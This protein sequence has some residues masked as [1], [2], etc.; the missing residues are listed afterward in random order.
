MGRGGFKKNHKNENRRK[1]TYELNSWLMEFLCFLVS[2][3]FNACP[4]INLCVYIFTPK[5]T[6]A[7]PTSVKEANSH[8]HRNADIF[9]VIRKP[10]CLT[11]VKA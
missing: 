11:N 3:D 2:F 4:P 6:Y 10:I 1:R 5:R 7:R 8:A 9:T